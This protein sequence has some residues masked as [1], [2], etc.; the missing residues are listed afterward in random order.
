[1]ESTHELPEAVAGMS[2]KRPPPEM[3]QED[4]RQKEIGQGADMTQI[5]NKVGPKST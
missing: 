4:R 5:S 2:V 1:M 3:F